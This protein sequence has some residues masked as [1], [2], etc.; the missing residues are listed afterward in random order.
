MSNIGFSRK[1]NG[2]GYV[3]HRESVPGSNSNKKIPKWDNLK[4]GGV[5]SEDKT[6]TRP[7]DEQKPL[8]SAGLIEDDSMNSPAACELLRTDLKNF[9]R[10]RYNYAVED[11]PVF[12]EKFNAKFPG[13]RKRLG[14]DTVMENAERL[15]TRGWS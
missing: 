13:Y 12:V 10:S 9:A 1:L 7:A 6:E 15:K 4:I 11:I 5:V 8:F 3:S 14:D 2:M